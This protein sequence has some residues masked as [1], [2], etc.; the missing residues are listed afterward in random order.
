MKYIEVDFAV[1]PLEIGSDILIAQLAEIGFE[2]FVETEI[3][4]KAYIQEQFFEINNISKLEILLN[5]NFT[6]TYKISNIED[7]NWNQLWESNYEPVNIDDKC[8]IKAPFHKQKFDAKYQIIIEPKMSFGTAHHETTASVIRLM[9]EIEFNNKVVLDMGSGTGVLAILSSMLGA[10]KVV[11][12]DNDSWAFENHL[13]NN[14]ANNI[15]NVDVILGD[16]NNIPNIEFDIIV[17][18][19]N[20]N[21]LLNDIRSYSKVLKNNG[22]IVFSGFYQGHD[23]E[24]IVAESKKYDLTLITNIVENNWTAAKFKKTI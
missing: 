19:I 13:E 2:S 22:I 16:A 3:G 15:S 9:F 17:A 10:K 21:I 20:R 8:I 4:A 5:K 23:L 14:L 18:N 24:M 12:I 6:I 1:Q 11:S 7:Q